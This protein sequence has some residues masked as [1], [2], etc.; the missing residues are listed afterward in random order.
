MGS[1]AYVIDFSDGRKVG[2]ILV[3]DNS[4]EYSAYRGMLGINVEKDTM[5][6]FVRVQ[7][8]GQTAKAA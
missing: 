2:A 3:G 6:A 4:E 5:M 1:I 8:E 7:S